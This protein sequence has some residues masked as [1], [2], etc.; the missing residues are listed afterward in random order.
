[1][2]DFEIEVLSVLLLDSGLEDLDVMGFV[3]TTTKSS[4]V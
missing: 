1:M 2:S 3:V 4:V